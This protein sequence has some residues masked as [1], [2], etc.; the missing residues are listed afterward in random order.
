MWKWSMI[1]MFNKLLRLMTLR[2]ALN[3]VLKV[4]WCLLVSHGT[5]SPFPWLNVLLHFHFAFYTM[6]VALSAWVKSPLGPIKGILC[7]GIKPQ[8]GSGPGVW[9][10]GSQPVSSNINESLTTPFSLVKVNEINWQETTDG[11]CLNG[12]GSLLITL[13]LHFLNCTPTQSKSQDHKVLASC[14]W[15]CA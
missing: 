8:R 4:E 14:F 1:E 11:E 2:T 13:A 12:R 3:M 10:S 6:P 7:L 9:C 5:G 15:K